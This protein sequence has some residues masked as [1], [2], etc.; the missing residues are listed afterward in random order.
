[1]VT[2]AWTQFTRPELEYLG[3]LITHEGIKP[4]Q[5]TKAMLKIKELK[6]VE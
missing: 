3:Y 1:M 6:M 5:K 2:Q 4:I